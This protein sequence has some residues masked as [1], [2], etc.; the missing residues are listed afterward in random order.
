[1]IGGRG[2]ASLYVRI[3][4]W[5]ALTCV[6]NLCWRTN[7]SWLWVHPTRC[8]VHPTHCLV[9]PIVLFILPIVVSILLSCPS[10]CR[11]HPIVVSIPLPCPSRC[12]VDPVCRVHLIVVFIL[13]S[14]SSCCSR[15]GGSTRRRSLGCRPPLLSPYH[16][17]RY[18][19]R[20]IL[21]L[22]LDHRPPNLNNLWSSNLNLG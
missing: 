20:I 19:P 12:P 7:T 22:F 5:A 8:P 6:W 9:Y 14:C 4:F 10:H 1:M 18:Y 2:Q 21:V 15:P 3:G 17:S 16:P 13:I 11:V